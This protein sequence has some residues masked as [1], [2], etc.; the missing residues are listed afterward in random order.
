MKKIN[1]IAIFLLLF[2]NIF[3]QNVVIE[4]P[5]SPLTQRLPLTNEQFFEQAEFI[6][7]GRLI[8]HSGKSYD[9]L[10]NLE[11]CE[12][13]Y[14]SSIIEV[15]HVYK[16]GDKIKQGTLEIITKGG[17]IVAENEMGWKVP[18]ECYNREE[19]VSSG[20]GNDAIFF[21]KTS[22]FPKNLEKRV[23]DNTISVSHFISKP[24][25]VLTIGSISY[26]T[27]DW[28]KRIRGLNNLNF[29][30][31]A[32]F[33]EYLKQFKGLNIPAVK[34]NLKDGGCSIDKIEEQKELV[35]EMNMQLI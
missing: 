18:Y 9:V 24:N 26:G 6:F 12:G 20:T 22:E 10:G 14:T 16:G 2:G 4:V 29:A 23:F 13:F 28:E 33:Y 21:C 5:N 15:K 25:A 19:I 1:L 17:T 27:K 32:E 3:S 7:E 35:K 8:A 30:N 34:D 11:C 31:R